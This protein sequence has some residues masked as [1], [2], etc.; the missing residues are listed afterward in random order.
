MPPHQ[1]KKPTD[2]SLPT[3]DNRSSDVF[4]CHCRVVNI[5]SYQPRQVSK[6]QRIDAIGKGSELETNR[7]EAIDN[8]T[9]NDQTLI[10]I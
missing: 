7:L 6:R 3:I 9:G 1:K 5:R 2:Q 8:L 4:L 10:R